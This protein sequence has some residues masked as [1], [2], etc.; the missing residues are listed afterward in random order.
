MS[1]L[2]SVIATV[3]YIAL[4]LYFLAMWARLILDFVRMLARHWRP[5]G[6]GLVLAEAVYTITDPPIKL[7]RRIIPP[8]RLGGVALDFAWSLVMLAVIILMSIP[9][10]FMK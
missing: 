6:L 7:V 10:S 4:L 1:S 9:P 2:V 5:R 3:I 8:L